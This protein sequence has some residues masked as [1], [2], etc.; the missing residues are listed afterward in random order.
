[1]L[2]MRFARAAAIALVMLAL[3]S[4]RVYAAPT[5]LGDLGLDDWLFWSDG[6]VEGSGAYSLPSAPA[7]LADP[8]CALGQPCF[9]FT[10]GV[11]ETIPG[12]RLRIAYDTSM[13]DDNFE[14]T[15]IDPSGAE[16][17]RTNGNQYSLEV[18]FPNPA[19]GLW[20]LRLVP[21]SAED[22]P[23]RLRAKLESETY[24]PTPDADGR[25]LP[26]LRVIRMWEFGFVAPANPLNG[27]FPPDDLNP[28]LSAAGVAPISCAADETLD[29]GATRCLR[30]SFGLAN[31]G[32]GV[33]D[34]R[35]TGERTD[36]ETHDMFQCVERGDGATETR[37]AGSGEFH[38]THGHWHYED[39]VYHE[40]FRVDRATDPPTLVS[41]GNGKKLGYS[42][43]DQAMPEWH[44]FVQAASGTSGSAG[45]CAPGSNNRLGMSRG[46]GD[47]YRYQRP[48]NYVEFGTNGDG[49]YVVQTIA[50]P[51]DHVLETDDG[52]N[53]AYAHLEVSGDEVTVLETGLGQSPWEPDREVWVDWWAE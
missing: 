16:T 29:D 39:V 27:L 32:D 11:T 47:A 48:G 4:D 5:H 40:L 28:P 19:T 13:R 3:T 14:L 31:V 36:V 6:R 22:A 30:Y 35:W 42:P 18:F 10:L 25:L 34:I 17:T 49:E 9:E 2:T 46:W 26:N 43:A 53:T 15:V 12:A 23:L 24:V 21:Y 44:R 50:D 1:M 33:F 38:T 51:L 41:T 8:L 20:T 45:N 52:D 37:P 7:A